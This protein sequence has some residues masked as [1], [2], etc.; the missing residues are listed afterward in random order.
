ME[1]YDDTP[2]WAWLALPLLLLLVLWTANWGKPECG[3]RIDD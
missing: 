2:W 1:N 3:G